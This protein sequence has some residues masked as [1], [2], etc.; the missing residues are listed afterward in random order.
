MRCKTCGIRSHNHKPRHNW[1]Y[2]QCAKCHYLGKGPTPIRSK[3][4]IL[5]AL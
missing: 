1:I 4:V 2:Q 5:N 3:K